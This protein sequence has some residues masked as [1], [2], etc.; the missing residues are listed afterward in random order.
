MGKVRILY[1]KEYIKQSISFSKRFS[2]IN[3]FSNS[4]K[5]VYSNLS[6]YLTKSVS[7][8]RRGPR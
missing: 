4:N 5:K 2:V 7:Y 6:I 8:G 1:T 3:S